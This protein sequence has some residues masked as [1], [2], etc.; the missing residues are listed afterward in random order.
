[1]LLMKFDYDWPAGFRDIHVWKCERTHGRRLESHTINLIA[2]K[3]QQEL[4]FLMPLISLPATS[5]P[6]Q[7]LSMA[8]ESCSGRKKQQ[9]TVPHPLPPINKLVSWLNKKPATQS[10]RTLLSEFRKW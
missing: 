4:K 9:K 7:P 6:E 8:N 5:L 2:I 10:S 1:M 3:K